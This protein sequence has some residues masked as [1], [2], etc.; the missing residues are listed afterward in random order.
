MTDQ[1]LVS[2]GMPCYDRPAMLRRAIECILNQTYRNIE[3]I[4]S[5]DASPNPE[6]Y[7]M[8][9]EYAAKDKRIRLFH[10]PVDLQVYGN[11]YFVQQQATGKYFFY[12]QDDDIWEP[13]FIELLV[14]NLEQHPENAFAICESRY[15]EVDGKEW[16]RLK[17]DNQSLATFIYGEKAPFVWMGLW[18]TELLRQ[19]DY[20][21]KDEHGKD[22]IIAAEA[23]MS[24]PFGYVDKLLYSKTLYH[25]K[26]RKYIEAKWYCHFQMYGTLLYRIAISKYAKKKWRL[27]YLTPL[28][29]FALARLYAAQILFLLPVNHPIRKAVRGIINGT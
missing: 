8:L 15:I 28:A 2:V 24:Y 16:Q 17:F 20:T 11:Y 4:I 13:Q 3:F 12:A 22:I 14:E 1:P 9:D 18:R 7:K 19:F 25:D 27:V 5:N 29:C 21:D 26:A 10:Q 6:I 23:L